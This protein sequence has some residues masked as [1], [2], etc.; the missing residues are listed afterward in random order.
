MII[1]ERP[2]PILIT[3]LE[4]LLRYL[5]KNHRKHGEVLSRLRKEKAGYRGE[6]ALNYPLSL[7]D[8]KEFTHVPSIRLPRDEYFFQI[9]NLL[10]TEKV[11]L[12]LESKNIDGVHEYDPIL[13]QMIRDKKD[14][15]TYPP[16]QARNQIEQLSRWLD[17]HHFPKISLDYLIINTHPNTIV[18]MTSYDKEVADKVIHIDAVYEKIMQVYNKSTKKIID[19]KTLLK[20]K[21][22][23]I[24]EH[25]PYNPNIL[26]LFQI[27]EK[28]L[29]KG[30]RCTSCSYQ[31]MIRRGG[32]WHCP[33]C[34]N[35]SKT[36]HHQ[37]LS[38]YFL[39]IRPL[40][41]NQECR[42]FFALNSAS[43][44]KKL[45]QSMNLLTT[46]TKKGTVYH[47]K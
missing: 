33:E 32:S 1:N 18:K 19:R 7:L 11:S 3:K 35:K 30:V 41:T 31:S 44:A 8:G 10:L 45:L 46:G 24:K 21:R 14:R 34:K 22:L 42:E 37:T 25:T 47:Y 5:P 17:K 16:L 2:I 12:V 6:L 15:F 28:E 26:E 27:D 29:L 9:D 39:L 13:K 23:I 43:I 20:I 38:D 36:A 40:I 4:V